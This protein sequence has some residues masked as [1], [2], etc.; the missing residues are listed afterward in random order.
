VVQSKETQRESRILRGLVFF[1]LKKRSVNHVFY[2][3]CALRTEETQHEARI[4]RGFVCFKL[5]KRS[6]NHVFYEG[7]CASGQ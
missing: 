3:V 4:L 6:V 2:K 5:K 7:L 1:K